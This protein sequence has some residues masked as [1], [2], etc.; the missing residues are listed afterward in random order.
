MTEWYFHFDAA[1]FVQAKQVQEALLNP[2]T[3]KP[4]ESGIVSP[5]TATTKQDA[6]SGKPGRVLPFPARENAKRRKQA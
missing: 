1:D 2:D 3:K 5:E 4:L 6:A